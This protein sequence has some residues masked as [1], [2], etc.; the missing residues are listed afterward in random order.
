MRHIFMKISQTKH[1]W[2]FYATSFALLLFTQPLQAQNT[3]S[4]CV[5]EL[6]TSEG[7]SSCPSGDNM[8]NSVVNATDNGNANNL[9]I[10]LHLELWNYLGWTDPYSNSQYDDMFF[11][12]YNNGN[13]ITFSGGNQFGTPLF[14]RNGME[15]RNYST[16]T[17]TKQATAWVDLSFNELTTSQLKVNYALTGD[18]S[19]TEVRFFLVE[20]GLVNY[21]SSGENGGMTLQHENV[22]RDMEV[23]PTSTANGIVTFTVPSNA[24]TEKMRVMAYIRKTTSSPWSREI[25]GA[26][27]G[28]KVGDFSG[29]NELEE[30]VEIGMFPNPTNAVTNIICAENMTQIDVVNEI[31][32]KVFTAN[33]NSH[34]IAVDLTLVENGI[35]FVKVMTDK[36][37][38][39]KKIIKI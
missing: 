19:N 16:A 15:G 17:Q 34:Q 31:G 20:R 30:S 33:P 11:G 22:A 9:Y 35:Y 28:F 3:N 25:V 6:F 12:Y 14:V 24:D 18:L 26:N 23:L 1:K 7:C 2:N 38:V 10:S 13:G 21:I 39:T 27:K 32:E 29:I 4:F 37:L 8:M 5:L 36:G